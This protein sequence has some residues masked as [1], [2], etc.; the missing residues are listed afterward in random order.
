MSAKYFFDTNVFVY[1][2]DASSPKKRDTAR[3]LIASALDEGTGI[4]S[5]QVA[6]EFLN[7]SLRKFAVPLSGKDAGKFLDTVLEP[8]CEVYPS[9][10]L[11]HAALDIGERWRLSFYDALIV[12]A[13]LEG[14]CAIL[15]SEDFQDTQTI[16][17]L[18]I[19]NPF[20]GL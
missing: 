7:V 15:Y 5:Y 8:L 16:R 10:E 20:K 4:I 17:D 18:R 6:Q 19:E 9:A 14:R 3:K 13:A 2:F 11:F 12:A 1:A